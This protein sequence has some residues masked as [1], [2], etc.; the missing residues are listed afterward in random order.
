[1][2]RN[3]G[4][5][6][7]SGGGPSLTEGVPPHSPPAGPHWTLLTCP[8]ALA[9]AVI[10]SACDGWAASITFMTRPVRLRTTLWARLLVP[11]TTDHHANGLVANPADCVAGFDVG[12]GDCT[13]AEG[14]GGDRVRLGGFVSRVVCR[15]LMQCAGGI[16]AAAGSARAGSFAAAL[17][18]P[19]VARHRSRP[20]SAHLPMGC[21][22]SIQ[23]S[24]CDLGSRI[25]AWPG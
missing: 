7:P 14:L 15:G 18:G 6:P 8:S 17:A 10:A 24:R 22:A 20:R 21:A 13:A 4:S 2:A 9:T 16:L 23:P 12:A 3:P 11:S 1:M 5:S 25:S 19:P